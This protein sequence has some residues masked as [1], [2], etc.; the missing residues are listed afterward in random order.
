MALNAWLS[1][2]LYGLLTLV[3]LTG[4]VHYGTALIICG[5]GIGVGVVAASFKRFGQA[6]PNDEQV[7]GALVAKQE[8]QLFWGFGPIGWMI[9][10]MCLATALTLIPMPVGL[11]QLLSPASADVYREAANLMDAPQG[12]AYL[13]VSSSKTAFALWHLLGF[14]AVYFTASQVYWHRRA[15]RKAYRF[16]WIPAGILAM[17]IVI[18]FAFNYDVNLGHGGQAAFGTLGL[19]ANHNHVSALLIIFSLTA[20]GSFS[21]QR[22]DTSGSFGKRAVWLLIY[23][24]FSILLVMLQSRAAIFAW[25]L[26]HLF[27]LMTYLIRR[28]RQKR[29]RLVAIVSAFGIFL[30]AAFYFSADKINEIKTELSVEQSFFSENMTQDDNSVLATSFEKTQIWPD[31]WTMSKDWQGFGYGR[32]AFSEIYPAYQGF[33]FEKRFRHAENEYL[34]ILVEYGFIWGSVCLL[35]GFWGIVRLTRMRS[36]YYEDRCVGLGML[37]GVVA[38]LFQNVFD[39]NLRYWT[40]G[41][42][43]LLVLGLLHGRSAYLIWLT[44]KETPKFISKE[45]LRKFEFYLGAGL[46]LFALVVALVSLPKAVEGIKESTL[47]DLRYAAMEGVPNLGNSELVSEALALHPASA[48]LRRYVGMAY[49]NVAQGKIDPEFRQKQIALALPWLESAHRRAPRDADIALTLG[50]TLEALGDAKGA[51]KHY[52]ASAKNDR[53]NRSLAMR[54]AARLSLENFS[55]IEQEPK[56]IALALV[57]EFIARKR[58]PEAFELLDRL[59]VA[60]YKQSVLDLLRCKIYRQIDFVEAC[61]TLV[62]A[63]PT[64]IDDMAQFELKLSW[65][66]E[67]KDYKKAFA[68]IELAEVSL[69]NEPEYWRLRLIYSCFYGAQMGQEWYQTKL[70]LLFVR[71]KRVVAAHPR[72]SFDEALCEAEYARQNG[73]TKRA[74]HAAQRALKFRPK[75]K[76]AL[77]IL[78]VVK[79]KS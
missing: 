10:A 35:L 5:L 48:D 27:M 23:V 37:S 21:G 42:L 76:R 11:L 13:T 44:E 78:E 66:I 24:F 16:F 4:G 79:P 60:G 59:A 31:I 68:A 3:V 6:K 7:Y 9:L 22:R 12:W 34:E 53:Y 72:L 65:W 58:Y 61:E 2:I 40:A 47:T 19:A 49:I 63:L 71:F 25:A 70:P 15:I 75:D 14:F 33:A 41:F 30:V 46:F 54:E 51:A 43:V 29:L 39:F 26:G 73:H 32:S 36:D 18:R 69:A 20:L 17:L 64:E 8:R 28:E 77:A 50:K 57:R 45:K 1:A 67:Q 56:Y 55:D 74:Y 62:D 38:V 52:I